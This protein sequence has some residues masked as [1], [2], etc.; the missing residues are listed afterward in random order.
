MLHNA[1]EEEPVRMG[2]EIENDIER[3]DENRR[4]KRREM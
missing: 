1:M 3:N 2:I 4:G